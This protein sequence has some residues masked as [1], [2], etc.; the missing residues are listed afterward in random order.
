VDDVGLVDPPGQQR[1][2]GETL[3][4][5]LL[6]QFEFLVRTVTDGIPDRLEAPGPEVHRAVRS[7]VEPH[8]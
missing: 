5:L 8:R 3:Q 2:R 7:N 4:R 1:E 6:R